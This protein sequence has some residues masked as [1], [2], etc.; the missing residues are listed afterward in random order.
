MLYIIS[1]PVNA[2]QVIT[3]LP[4]CDETT[5]HEQYIL[6]TPRPVCPLSFHLNAGNGANVLNSM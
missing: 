1:Q 5:I 2:M 6:E 3:K 4:F